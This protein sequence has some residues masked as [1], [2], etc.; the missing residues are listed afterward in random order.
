MAKVHERTV[1]FLLTMNAAADSVTTTGVNYYRDD[2][3]L[4]AAAGFALKF[5]L[6]ASQV[7]PFTDVFLGELM[8]PP[9]RVRFTFAAF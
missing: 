6:S 2:A 1:E 7:Q 8:P 4:A 9:T 5:T 3:Q